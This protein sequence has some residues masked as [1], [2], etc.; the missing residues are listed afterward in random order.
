M[1]GVL[2]L[3]DDTVASFEETTATSSSSVASTEA[4]EEATSV[5]TGGS[6]SENSASATVLSSW[7]D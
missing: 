3:E 4:L 6:V 1:N 2:E 7:E 5:Y